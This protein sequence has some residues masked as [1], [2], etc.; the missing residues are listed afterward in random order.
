MTFELHSYCYYFYY[1]SQ[2]TSE[3]L[4]LS[5]RGLSTVKDFLEVE[6]ILSFWINEVQ[7]DIEIVLKMYALSHY[8]QD[9][10][11]ILM[12]K[13][14]SLTEFLNSTSETFFLL[15]IVRTDKQQNQFSARRK[16]VKICSKY[17]SLLFFKE[18]EFPSGLKTKLWYPRDRTAPS[19]DDLF[20]SYKFDY[21]LLVR[22]K[23]Q[24]ENKKNLNQTKAC[25]AF[26]QYMHERDFL[27]LYTLRKYQIELQKGKFKKSRDN[28]K[29][30]KRVIGRLLK[31][32]S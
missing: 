31:F 8:N 32:F 9:N 22:I 26:F 18:V 14:H 16:N 7:S 19:V 28:P 10:N 21:P 17:T 20:Y 29:W 6:T 12:G 3:S 30:S 4:D 24:I 23:S 25:L 2:F 27:D 1:R 11:K 15:D 13:V 5:E